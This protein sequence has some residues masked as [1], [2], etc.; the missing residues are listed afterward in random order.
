MRCRDC[1]FWLIERPEYTFGFCR[2]FPPQPHRHV[3]AKPAQWREGIEV[4]IQ[5][6]SRPCWV[7]TEQDDWCGEFLRKQL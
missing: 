2:R 3:S 7:Q 1:K 4:T 5:D 6:I